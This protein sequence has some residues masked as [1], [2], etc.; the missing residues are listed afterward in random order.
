M[1]AKMKTTADILVKCCMGDELPLESSVIADYF[2]ISH[3]AHETF[4]TLF[5][6]Y[7]DLVKHK[8]VDAGLL[9]KCMLA[10]KLDELIEKKYS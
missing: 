5:G 1:I 7:Q 2:R 10:N 6:V 8:D 3:N 4:V 9:H